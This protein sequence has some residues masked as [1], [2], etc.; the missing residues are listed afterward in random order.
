MNVAM[1]GSLHQRVH[2]VPGHFD[3]RDPN[4]EPPDVQYAP[5]H[6]IQIAADSVLASWAGGTTARVN[7]LHGQ[8]IKRLAPELRA[9][10]HAPDGL[11]EAFEVAGA[12][13]FALAVQWHPEWRCWD[14]PFYAAIFQAF[15]EACWQ[16]AQ[17]RAAPSAAAFTD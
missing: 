13:T 17:Q 10:A 12:T 4:G 14:N 8:G 1:G 5:A 15:G 16:R 11:V 9:L 7:S 2:Q 6:D 3:H